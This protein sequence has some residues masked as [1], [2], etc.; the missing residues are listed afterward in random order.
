MSKKKPKSNLGKIVL[1]IVIVAIVWV[2][3]KQKAPANAET[4][5]QVEA[6]D[7]EVQVEEAPAESEEVQPL[8][9]DLCYAEGGTPRTE[10]DADETSIGNVPGFKVPH[11]C[12]V[13][14]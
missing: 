6:P 12:C 8:Y 4:E 1:L 13:A 9:P 3:L 14:E 10:C 2:V 5:E 11:V 7:V